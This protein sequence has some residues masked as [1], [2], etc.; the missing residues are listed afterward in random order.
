[1]VWQN[2]KGLELDKWISQLE[3]EKLELH[4]LFYQINIEYETIS[5]SDQISQFAK[6]RLQMF[7]A[8]RNDFVQMGIHNKNKLL[9]IF[10]NK[11]SKE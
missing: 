3:K 1:M 10:H 6:E 4:N 7:H 9:S 5:N 11:S 8:E 2:I